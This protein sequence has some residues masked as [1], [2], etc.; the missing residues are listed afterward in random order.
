MFENTKLLSTFLTFKGNAEEAMNFYVSL[1]PNEAK[2]HSVVKFEEGQNGPVGKIL[3]ATV[4]IKGHSLMFMDMEPQFAP[5]F[6]WATSLLVVCNE[7]AQ[8][9]SLFNSLSK[10]G[11]IM[12]GPEA[13]PPMRKVAWITDR[14]GVT[15]QLVWS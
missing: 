5:D 4:E 3:N 15:W 1:F 13:I 14:F 10:D 7:E 12:M 6:S 2:I 8:F 9:D 11:S